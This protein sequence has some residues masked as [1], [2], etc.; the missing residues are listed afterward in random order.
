MPRYLTKSR[1]KLALECPTKLFYTGKEK[2]KDAKLE[3]KFLM[4]LAEG[5]FQVG[6]LAK[7]YYP[8]GINI[9]EIDHE[10]ALAI[11]QEHLKKENV[12]LFEAAFV[13]QDFFVRADVVIKK[14]NNLRLIEVKSKSYDPQKDEF[15]GKKGGILQKWKTYIYDISFQ[16]YVIVNAFPELNVTAFLCLTDK[17]VVSNVDGL[18]QLFFLY[19]EGNRTK[20][21]VKEIDNYHSLGNKILKEVGV[22][23]IV[24]RIIAGEFLPDTKFTSFKEMAESYAENYKDDKKIKQEILGRC[25]DCEFKA[26][27]EELGQGYLSGFRECW[28]ESLSFK[29]EDFEMPLIIDIWDFRKKDE[30]INSGKYFMA[31]VVMEDLEGKTKAKAKTSNGL[32][33]V[34]RQYLQVE[35]ATNKDNTNYIDIDGLKSEMS[36]WKYPLHFIDFETSA[37]AVPFNKGRRPYEQIAFQFSHHVVYENGTIEHFSEWINTNRGQFPNFE[38]VRELKKSLEND[39]GT[40]FRYAAHENSILNAI[41]VQLTESTEADKEELCK[42]IK[43]ITKSKGDSVEVWEG[44]RNMVDLLEMVKKYYYSPDMGGSNSLKFVLPAILNS[45]DY[46]KGKYSK[47]IYGRDIKSTNFSDQAW[48]VFENEKLV[49]PYKLLP[50]INDGYDNELLDDL[51]VDDESGIA[52]GGAAMIAYARMQ[53]TE[54]SDEE[55]TRICKALLRYCELDTFAMVM[56]WEAWNHWCK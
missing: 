22:D 26:T 15:I 52:D 20:V 19:K 45:S 8:E 32:S 48:I 35:K 46:L 54:M 36:K 33:R 6:E 34:E 53:F 31:Q 14:G 17:S 30:L 9:D 29:D 7:L 56:L 27:K 41:Y 18:N 21:R 1:F 23:D 12:I 37:V 13:F 4:A 11:T 40:I 42:W 28:S 51:V 55:H 3:D 39:D 5:G 47:P 24:D 44:E 38:F 10:K 43:T 2:Y 25:K 50:A 49:N 16:K